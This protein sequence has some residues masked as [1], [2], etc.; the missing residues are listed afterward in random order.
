MLPNLFQ[1]KKTTLIFL[2]F[3][4]AISM[5]LITIGFTTRKYFN[6]DKTHI[7]DKL[8]IR[9]EVI[10]QGLISPW[11]FVFLK[12][13]DL[14]FTEKGGELRIIQQ[15]KLLEE[16]IK[17]LP[18][19]Y[20]RGQGGLMDL[21][22]HPDYADNG[23]IYISYSSQDESGKESGGNTT[24]MRARIRNHE[25]V[26]KRVLFKA[27][28]NT[29]RGQHFGG[30]IEFDNKGFLYLSVGDRGE[31]NLAQSTNNYNGKI[32]RLH[33]DGTIPNDNPFVDKKGALKAIYSYGHR[34]P[35]GL[36]FNTVTGEMWE[37]EHGPRG[38]D[39]VN[40]IRKGNNYGW[41]VITYGINYDGSIITRDTVKAGMEQPVIFWR[42][43]IAPCGMAFITSDKYPGWKGDLLVGSL[44][45]QYVVRCD[46]RG[47]DILGQ[48]KILEGLGRIRSI[49]QGPDGYIY[50]SA[51]GS[52]MI[53]RL[54]PE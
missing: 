18:K 19:I 36:A 51:E 11:S 45:F 38:G 8:K 48:E 23:W 40:I 22:L 37:T 14:L 2:L 10:A 52:G 39:E 43:S 28:P 35:Q 21:E 29:T 53:V 15:G 46:V 42:P 44:K 24:L 6:P 33:D 5:A 50:V 31:R 3:F 47:N 32:F 17:G 54:V 12:N 30:R 16:P 25:L 26:D 13:G 49:R 41:P 27:T 34:N 1:M 4:A 9:T 20:V 7:T